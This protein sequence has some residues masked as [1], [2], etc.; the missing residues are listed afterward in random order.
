MTLEPASTEPG[1]HDDCVV[2]G[3]TDGCK[4]VIGHHG[5]EKHVQYCKEYENIHLGD[6][7]FIGYNFA[8]CPYVLQHLWDGC[9]GETDVY[10]G[11]VGEEEVHGG[12]EVG[13]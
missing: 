10:K 7:A 12:V 6:T 5:Q 13:V 1:V 8:L 9:G 3:V 11:Q 2:Q 4:S